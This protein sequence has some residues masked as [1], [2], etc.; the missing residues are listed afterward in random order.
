MGGIA[1]VPLFFVFE[2]LPFSNVR[3]VA[4]GSNAS[5]RC[6]CIS[7]AEISATTA[8]IRNLDPLLLRNLSIDAIFLF[9]C[10]LS[11]FALRWRWCI[12][13]CFC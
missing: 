8:A 10:D 1:N 3:Q 11:L 6:G 9:P 13:L 2:F 7:C 12:R 5:I 4:T